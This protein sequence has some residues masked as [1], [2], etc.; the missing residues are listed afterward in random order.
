[1]RFAVLLIL[2][3]SSCQRS[4]PTEAPNFI[5][6][7]ASDAH[8]HDV[9]DVG[10]TPDATIDATVDA[11]VPDA[12]RFDQVMFAATHNSYSG[13][14]RGS[15][16]AQLEIGVRFIEL[17]VHNDDFATE[18]FGIGHDDPG[19][20]V[21]LGEENPA[22]TALTDWLDVV[23]TWRDDNPNH[24]P[25]TL[26]LDLKDDLFEASTF[27]DGNLARLNQLVVDTFGDALF[28]E[29]DAA[30][31][32]PDVESMRGRVLI[33]LSGN[34]S[35]R[36]G[37]RRVE[38]ANPSVAAGD[39]AVL[40]AHESGDDVVLWS[41]PRDFTRYERLGGVS[42]PAV[43]LE[44]SDVVLVASGQVRTGAARCQPRHHVG[45]PVRGL[46][47]S[48]RDQPCGAVRRRG[49]DPHRRRRGHVGRHVER[50]VTPRDLGVGRRRDAA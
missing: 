10:P 11:E 12:T 33:V 5:A 8:H 31:G 24:L 34:T 47:R 38:G 1:M 40:V 44:C 13:E 21:A 20:E 17:D 45:W 6:D 50:H 30:S 42:D 4:G 9:T 14:G 28:T 48:R 46:R 32:W 23:Q 22:G 16:L 2:L 3:L 27:A 7:A 41:G 26:G 29:A 19:H 43:D 37:Y 36:L 49:H 39:T 15:I 25:L 35:S 18:G